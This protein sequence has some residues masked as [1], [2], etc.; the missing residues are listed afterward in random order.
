[1]A[2][3]RRA[4]LMEVHD[5]VSASLA[6]ASMALSRGDSEVARARAQTSIADGIREVSEIMSLLGATAE[7]WTALVADVRRSIESA[8]ESSSMALT[9]EAS[10]DPIPLPVPAPVA[11]VIRRVVR[12]CL[13]NAIKHASAKHARVTMVAR[14]DAYV[15]RIEDDGVGFASASENV[16][17]G[18]RGLRFMRSRLLRIGGSLRIESLAPGARVEASI[19]RRRIED[20]AAFGA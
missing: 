8:A 18:G 20:F 17:A 9:L 6:R 1:L 15:V 2:E 3:Q 16:E 5:G 12:E 4:L 11:H 7:P 10:D 14:D 13:T 19:P